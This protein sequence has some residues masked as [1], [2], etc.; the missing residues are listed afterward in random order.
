MS[1]ERTP[2]QV[3]IDLRP[4]PLQMSDGNIFR[5]DPDPGKQFFETV[6]RIRQ[7]RDGD[8]EADYSFIDDLRKILASQIVDPEERKAFTKRAYGLPALNDISKTYSRAVLG[9]TPT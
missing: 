1:D 4:I 7:E 3:G 8:D 6:S 2:I 5:F 9:D